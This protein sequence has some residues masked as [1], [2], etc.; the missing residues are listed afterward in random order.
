L[1]SRARPYYPSQT[2]TGATYV[3]DGRTG[4]VVSTVNCSFDTTGRW[5]IARQR[6]EHMNNVHESVY[7]ARRRAWVLVL[8]LVVVAAVSWAVATR[9]LHG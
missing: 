5:H 3:V 1:R 4:K 9:L 8:F 6:A 2:E 7:F